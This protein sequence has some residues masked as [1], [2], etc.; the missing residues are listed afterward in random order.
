MYTNYAHNFKKSWM[1]VFSIL[2]KRNY[3]LFHPKLLG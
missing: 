2:M 1:E 3:F